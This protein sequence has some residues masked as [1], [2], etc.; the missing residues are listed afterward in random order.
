MPWAHCATDLSDDVAACPACGMSK[1]QWTVGFEAT[2]TFKLSRRAML[3]LEL[4][5]ADGAPVASEAYR[6]T[7]ADGRT[8]DGALDEGG[9]AVVPATV[10]GPVSVTFP[11]LAPLDLVAPAGVTS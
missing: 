7:F 10:G 6:A 3:N 2:R 4:A 9:R 1:T 8:V 5:D 11:D